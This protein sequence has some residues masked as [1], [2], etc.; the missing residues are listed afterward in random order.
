MVDIRNSVR[1]DLGIA[2]EF[3]IQPSEWLRMPYWLYEYY[4]E[5]VMK[6]NKK[7]QEEREDQEKQQQ[8]SMPKIPN[9]SQLQ[10]QF[11]M[12][13]MPTYNIPKF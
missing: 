5:E 7:E 10:S 1:N 9:M 12:P 4:K 11:K 13:P 2:R 3:H 6:I 8:Q